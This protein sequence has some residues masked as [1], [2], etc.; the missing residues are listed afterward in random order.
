MTNHIVHP[1]APVLAGQVGLG[2]D[3]T[4]STLVGA[5][6]VNLG[7]KTSLSYTEADAGYLSPSNIPLTR[8]GD[9]T[10]LPIDVKADFKG[11]MQP[12]GCLSYFLQE[13]DRSIV[14]LRPGYNGEF[15]RTFYSYSSSGSF[16]AADFRLTDSEYRPDWLSATEY[17]NVIIDSSESGFLVLIRDTVTLSQLRYYWVEHNGTLDSRFHTFLDVTSTVTIAMA[18]YS[19]PASQGGG[20]Y[21]PELGMFVTL[22]SNNGT[23]CQALNWFTVDR[24]FQSTRSETTPPALLAKSVDW[25]DMTG[26]FSGISNNAVM[27]DGLNMVDRL[28][29]VKVI[30]EPGTPLSYSLFYTGRRQ[31]S[32]TYHS[33]VVRF[34]SPGIFYA[35]Y[36]GA[37]I[38]A[39]WTITMDYDV[40]S[41]TL[42]H[43]PVTDDPQ[44]FQQLPY[45]V[46]FGSSTTQETSPTVP[47]PMT[48]DYKANK[49]PMALGL[50]A[51]L[52]AT[53]GSHRIQLVGD[54]IV[55]SYV[56]GS[57]TTGVSTGALPI[58]PYTGTT[59]A[60]KRMD[61][62]RRPFFNRVS[63]ASQTFIATDASILSKNLSFVSFIGPN[64][65]RGFST[66][67]LYGQSAT[68]KS[69][70]ATLPGLI[71]SDSVYSVDS[72]SYKPSLPT[73]TAVVT[74]PTYLSTSS[75]TTFID[76]NGPMM[77]SR[78]SY[79]NAAATAATWLAHDID[80]STGI[81]AQT[82]SLNVAANTIRMNEM[83][84]LTIAQS[85]FTPTDSYTSSHGIQFL[86]ADHLNGFSVFLYSLAFGNGS[87]GVQ[88]EY[89]T[90]QLPMSGTEVYW[91]SG[92][93]TAE[94]V[95]SRVPGGF[96]TGNYTAASYQTASESVG[97]Y[98][99]TDGN[100]Y[101]FSVIPSIYGTIGGNTFELR[102]FKLNSS[103]QITA[104]KQL[105]TT[106]SWYSMCAGIHPTFGL[107]YTHV[108]NDSNA[109]A[110]MVYQNFTATADQATRLQQA[111]D[112]VIASGTTGSTTV[113]ILSSKSA[114]GFVLYSSDIPVFMNGNYGTLPTQTIQLS[115]IAA[116]PTN[117]TFFFYVQWDGATFVLVPSLV[118]I[119]ES[120]N[121]TLLGTVVTNSTGIILNTIEKVTRIDTYRIFTTTPIIGS[122]IRGFE[123]KPTIQAYVFDTTAE[124]D[125]FKAAF[126]PPSQSEVF[127]TWHRTS[128]NEYFPGGVGATGD[129]A[130]WTFATNPDRIVQPNNT[131]SY[132][133]FISPQSYDNY[134]FETTLSSTNSDDDV[135]GMTAAFARVGA[136]NH[137]L[138]VLRSAGGVQQ[139][140]G[141]GAPGLWNF[142]F[143]FEGVVLP[144]IDKP[145]LTWKMVGVSRNNTTG[146]PG[147]AGIMTRIRVVRR[148]NIITAY[149]SDWN[150]S[151]TNVPILESSIITLD[152]TT[153]P[154][155]APLLTAAPYGYTTLSQSAATYYD[156]TFAGGLDTRRVIDLQA[157]L[158]WK[159]DFISESWL[160]DA[161]TPINE[162][163]Y[164]RTITNPNTNET[165]LVTQYAITK[166]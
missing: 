165:Y 8:V 112:K 67:K 163:G 57:T 143:A 138:M 82:R 97:V 123:L 142:G 16:A 6:T 92:L 21:I 47:D 2:A 48:D 150:L 161:I 94:H 43:N 131:N 129:A 81:P 107:Y 15:T 10:Y 140:N 126:V 19:S 124:V 96:R 164:V 25:V 77:I 137:Q 73:P 46:R 5:T 93:T 118:T 39:A 151:R 98:R 149:C 155:L 135:I 133:S 125:S 72:N 50:G 146:G 108:W 36:T 166:Q 18:G 14:S 83:K 122:A 24:P 22:S 53:N 4:L 37:S 45:V 136:V 132:A 65:L 106:A 35:T 134:E 160:Q 87:N 145:K 157:N 85:T 89:A 159:Y 64:A 113:F 66:S 28:K 105:G 90:I 139:S 44:A 41:N 86:Y 104:N 69:F 110:S 61:A 121:S 95:I 26:T 55:G 141:N 62:F 3:G 71:A 13:Q 7:S 158:V 52:T 23:S 51:N 154:A 111:C 9:I 80:G 76:G 148:G 11:S 68:T 116:D 117:K 34:I 17:V 162:L 144:D 63:L 33:G 109:K 32:H 38:A 100:F 84:A 54:Y 75:L 147:W 59:R 102:A 99:H 30:N 156:T 130:A 58:A 74:S 101:V 29:Y 127:N 128:A 20:N 91:D 153:I 56:N 60:E 31:L 42:R 152:M 103:F 27:V 119:P 120:V 70:I 49:F 115:S 79:G 78:A 1:L 40:A 12:W 114:S 88:W